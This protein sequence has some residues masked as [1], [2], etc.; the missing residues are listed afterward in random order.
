[1]LLL[2]SFDKKRNS[3]IKP[4]TILQKTE[5]SFSPHPMSFSFSP[6]IPYF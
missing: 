3:G 4:E 6:N 5:V 1:M 2:N